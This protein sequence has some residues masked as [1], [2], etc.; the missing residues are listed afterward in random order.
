MW[1][2]WQDDDE[3]WPMMVMTLDDDFSTSQHCSLV[4]EIID[5]NKQTVAKAQQCE[6]PW[7]PIRI[8]ETPGYSW[9]A[10]GRNRFWP[11]EHWILLHCTDSQVTGDG[12]APALVSA[13]FASCAIAAGAAKWLKCHTA[14][15]AWA[16]LLQPKNVVER[17]A[18]SYRKQSLKGQH[19]AQERLTSCI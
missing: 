3:E 1:G 15:M 10:T 7:S 19:Y 8:L 14:S 9:L 18:K 11:Y 4:M 12:F 17:H 6:L 16:E 13:I 5:F 2:T